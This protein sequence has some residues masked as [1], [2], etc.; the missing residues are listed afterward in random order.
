M[1]IGA[2]HELERDTGVV[3]PILQM[4]DR[5]TDIWPTVMEEAR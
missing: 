2:R 5:T 4:R 3:K 1:V